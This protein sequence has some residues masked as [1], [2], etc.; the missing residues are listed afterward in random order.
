MAFETEFRKKNKNIAK[1]SVRTYL[2]NIRR[3]AKALKHEGI[4]EKGMWLKQAPAY[5][6]KQPL[7]T[8]KLLSVAAI[9]ASQVYGIK[10]DVISNIVKKASDD[11]EAERSKGKKTVRDKALMPKNGYAAIAKAAAILRE[12]VP[13]T[14]GNMKDYMK[15]QD[16]WLLSFFF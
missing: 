16:A 3:L 12:K 14:V 5:L 7:N 1:S 8:R 9:K 6:R 10:H 13:E 2:A 4:P 15:L 11:Y